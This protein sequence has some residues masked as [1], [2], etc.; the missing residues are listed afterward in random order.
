MQIEN[1]EKRREL[2]MF[3]F[4]TLILAPALAVLFVSAFGFCVWMYQLIAGPP[5]V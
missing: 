5:G 2:A 4:L 3:V 1:N